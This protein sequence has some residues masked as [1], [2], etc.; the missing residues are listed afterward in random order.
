MAN[1]ERKKREQGILSDL[2]RGLA[3]GFRITPED[4][5]DLLWEIRDAEGKS[6]PPRGTQVFGT[7]PIFDA[8]RQA[9]TVD[10]KRFG[11]LPVDAIN[12]ETFIRR[13]NTGLNFGPSPIDLIG[14]QVTDANLQQ[15]KE[16]LHNQ[17][18]VRKGAF[19]GGSLASDVVN[20]GLRG[21]YWLLNA[22]QA[23]TNVINEQGAAML[24]PDLFANRVVPL[25]EAQEKGWVAYQEPQL[26]PEVFQARVKKIREQNSNELFTS[27]AE[28]EFDMSLIEEIDQALE[29]DVTKRARD[30]LIEESKLQPQNYKNTRPGVKIR[31]NRILKRRFNPN[32][33]QAATLIPA[34]IAINSGIGLLGRNEGYAMTVP[35]DD[36][37]FSTDNVIAEVAAKYITG[38]EGRLLEAEDFLLERPDVTYGEYQK[39][40]GYLRDRDVDLNPFDDAKINLGGLLKTNPDGIRGAEVSFMGK[41]L[42]VNDTLLGTAGAI[43]GAAGGAALTNLGS[44]RLRG[45]VKARKGL[46]KL[47]AFVPEVLP[48]Q[49]D[50]TRTQ[51]HPGNQ[52]INDMQEGFD[53]DDGWQHNA[54]VLGTV[55]GGG[56]AGLAA[57]ELTGNSIEDE[58]RRRNFAEN[59]P[60]VDYDIYK[61]NAKQL[62][63]DKYEV[64]RANPNAQQEKDKSRTG[65]NKRSQQQSLNTKMLQQQA[66]VDQ[67]IDEDRRAQAGKALGT[68]QW[69]SQ[70]FDAIESEIGKR[71]AKKKEE[72]QQSMIQF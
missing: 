39:Y 46:G 5:R 33:V 51:A 10:P 41:T 52:F 57:G 1:E 45:G 21:I 20:D 38:R 53:K 30:E 27:L 3:E 65:F 23:T 43:L 31:S 6:E 56:M 34:G 62:L 37:P 7:Q 48:R 24:N 18:R 9:K 28:G 59:N 35:K 4:R 54:R 25:Q 71:N 42:P 2:K 19:L 22:P 61:E 32:I 66:L 72:E 55:F 26:D 40:K 15:Y 13:A 60:G 67:L 36:D 16:A 49:R 47:G 8:A 58:R 69:A 68:Q 14:E 12:N 64:M 44:I 17:S 63:T 70:K 11:W 29:A 50:G